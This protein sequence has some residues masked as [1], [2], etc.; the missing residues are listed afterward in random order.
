MKR[1]RGK[2]AVLL[3]LILSFLMLAVH[4]HLRGESENHAH[5]HHARTMSFHIDDPHGEQ[6]DETKVQADGLDRW[7][8]SL[9][10][11][12]WPEPALSE[13]TVHYDIH[14]YLDEKEMKLIGRQ[15]VVWTHPG[16]LPVHEVYFHAYPNAFE[17]KKTS[18]MRESGGKLRQDKMPKGGYGHMNI[19]RIVYSRY[20]AGQT[21]KASQEN[22][23]T[24]WEL[25]NS[26][27]YVQPDDGNRHDRTL[28][29]VD[30]PEPVQPG[31]QAVFAIDFTVKLPFAFARMGVVD[32]FVMAGQWFPKLS[33]FETEGR[34]GRARE[35]WNAHQYHGNSEF[36]AD[37][38]TYRV[39][40]DVPHDYIV[41]ATGI[42][43]GEPRQHENRSLHRFIAYDV[44]DFAWAAS[45]HFVVEE[46]TVRQQ[47]GDPVRLL[48]YLDPD[49]AHLRDR[50]IKAASTAL[51]R[52]G[53]WM[54]PYPYPTLS[55][56]VPPKGGNG[57]GGMEYPALITAWAAEKSDPGYELERVVIHEI[58]HQYF[59]GIL[60][61]N[62]F[63][64]AWLDEA[65]TSYVED[66]VM[67]EEYKVYS[68]APVEAGFVTTPAP[69]AQNAWEYQD[70]GHYADNVYVRGKLVLREIEKRIGTELMDQALKQYYKHWKFKHPSTQDFQQVLEW[71]SGESWDDFFRTFIY[72]G[73][74]TDYAIVSVQSQIVQQHGE[75]VYEHELFIEKQ[76]AEYPRVP[77]QLR[78]EDGSVMNRL[79]DGRPERQKVTV[80]HR[81]PLKMAVLDPH[82]TML[83]ENRR[84]NNY[85][86][87]NVDQNENIRWTLAI[88]HA[89]ENMMRLWVW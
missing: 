67:R 82:Y 21:E 33:A 42:A 55:V 77:L 46:H 36:Y 61:N 20:P 73:A 39:T 86:R 32:D 34:R 43:V 40:M 48:L 70:H 37:F 63:E 29:R 12:S 79:L 60:A 23:R 30:L 47:N 53:E 3:M 71:I 89:V 26:S 65:F 68:P 19:G 85:M 66:R 87:G 2:P 13:R 59:Y 6:D 76:G 51:K 18:F 78:F 16:R 38:G 4:T 83:L 11:A 54:G 50:Y 1:L 9:A 58:G 14:V 45:P 44:H 84:L 24:S 49:H 15:L 7:L 62:E 52:F 8:S 27:H 64:E 75:T 56:V 5:E 88:V 74:M 10:N 25:S 69:L 81:S 72:G 17:S 41:A 57:A 31:E 28:L 35:G 80:L 22:S